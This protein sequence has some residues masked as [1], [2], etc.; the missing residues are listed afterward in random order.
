MWLCCLLTAWEA[1][2]AIKCIIYSKDSFYRCLAKR[3]Y[4]QLLEQPSIANSID[5]KCPVNL[6]CTPLSLPFGEQS[7]ALC[8]TVKEK[9]CSKKIFLEVKSNHT[10]NCK[11]LCQIKEYGVKLVTS[12]YHYLAPCSGK[13]EFE[14]SFVAPKATWE[15]RN[16][17]PFKYVRK[18]YWVMPLTTLVGNIGGTAGMFV[19]FSFI[20]AYEWLKIVASYYASLL[21]Q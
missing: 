4:K 21:K 17:E 13:T 14:Y 19:G 12:K 9:S 10:E 1:L 5:S 6:T 18:E 16:K 2:R 8:K 15:R 11:K 7:M 3:F 20:T